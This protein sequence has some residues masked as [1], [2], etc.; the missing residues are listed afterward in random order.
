MTTPLV[1]S[2]SNILIDFQCCE[3]LEAMLSLPYNFAVPDV[4]YMEE[5]IEDHPE[6]PALGLRV[7]NFGPEVTGDIEFLRSRYPTPSTNDLMAL[8]LAR[9]LSADLLS[10]DAQLR[11]AAKAEKHPCHGSIWLLQ[12]M[13]RRS[14]IGVDAAIEALDR[15]KELGRRLPWGSA[16][17][18]LRALR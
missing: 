12:E 5:L 14:V 15:M 4:L 17:R 1:I 11:K 3:L 9:S 18:Q 6:L 13:V 10:G 16:K 8:A 2:D 7:V